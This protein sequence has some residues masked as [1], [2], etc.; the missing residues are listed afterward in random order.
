MK[1]IKYLCPFLV[2]LPSSSHMSECIN[3]NG[4]DSLV[5]DLCDS[6]VIFA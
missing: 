2:K 5:T 1:V 3:S 6:F 4:S